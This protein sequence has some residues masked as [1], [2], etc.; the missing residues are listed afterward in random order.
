MFTDIV[1]PTEM[2][3]RLGDV[4]SV[5][6]VRAHDGMVRQALTDFQGREVKHLGDGIMASFDDVPAALGAALSSCNEVAVFSAR[7][8]EKLQIRIGIDAGEPV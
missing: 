1:G 7:S 4:G 5:E 8:R 6:M 3:A 2:T